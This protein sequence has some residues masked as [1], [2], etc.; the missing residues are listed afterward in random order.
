M[1]FDFL[2]LGG[3]GLQGK[4]VT[5]D[6]LK[7]SYSVL[8]CGRDKSRIQNLLKKYKKTDFEYVD[9]R[10]IKHAAQVIKKSG[11]DV[12]V[13]CAEEDWDLNALKACLIAGAHLLD[14]GSE[15]PM[16]KKQFAL[17]KTLKKKGLIHIT[18]CGSVP[19]I[20]NVMLNHASKKFGS[21]ETIEVGYAWNSNIKKF[22]VPFS[23]PTILTEFTAPA[24]NIEN[25]KI[26]NIIPL[27]TLKDHH[28]KF[29]GEEKLFSVRHPETYTFYHYFKNKGLKTIRFYGEFPPHSFEKIMAMIDLGL[30]GKRSIKIKGRKIVPLEFLTELLKHLK[31]PKGYKEKEDLWVTIY[32]KKNGKDKVIKMNCVVPT[33]K[34]WEDAGCNIDTGMPASI[35]AQLVKKGLIKERGAFAPE[36]IIPPEPF[37]KELRKRKMVV[38]ENGKIIN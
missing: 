14:L 37:F 10:N 34:G 11:A 21:I 26:I 32:G 6:L 3:T 38:Y 16:T 25:G 7:N 5:K 33:L 13:N 20:G 2:V 19:G 27:S 4:I 12:V 24:T 1:K 18:G 30:G 22:V 17:D 28:D 8:M 9:L 15:I 36:A 35:M 31:Y 23:I 29:V